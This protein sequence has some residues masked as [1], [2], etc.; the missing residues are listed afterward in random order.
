MYYIILVELTYYIYGLLVL[1]ALKILKPFKI[2][3]FYVFTLLL[4]YY[5]KEGCCIEYYL[6]L[7]HTTKSKT[8]VTQ[9]S[10][11]AYTER[12]P[13]SINSTLISVEVSFLCFIVSVSN[14][15]HSSILVITN[16]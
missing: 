15:E 3:F 4:I 1:N 13:T 5:I 12:L 7:S 8:A 16:L 6:N 10:I 11:N 9:C 2:D 14:A